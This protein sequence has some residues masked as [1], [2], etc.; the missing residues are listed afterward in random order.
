MVSKQLVV[1]H[2]LVRDN[3]TEYQKRE[4]DPENTVFSGFSLYLRASSN[5]IKIHKIVAVTNK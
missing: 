5:S 1:H 2:S 4:T 3:S